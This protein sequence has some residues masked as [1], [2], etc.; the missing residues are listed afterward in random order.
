MIG[1]RARGAGGAGTR[2]HQPNRALTEED[3]YGKDDREDED[4]QG[5]EE[6]EER[7]HV[8]IRQIRA[9]N[10]EDNEVKEEHKE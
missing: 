2:K 5:Q 9:S 6:Q 4:E 10:E 1:A 7:E 8:N 3:N